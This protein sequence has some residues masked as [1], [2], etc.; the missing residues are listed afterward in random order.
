MGDEKLTEETET[1]ETVQ[2]PKVTADYIRKQEH[3]KIYSS[4][5]SF[6][7]TAVSLRLEDLEMKGIMK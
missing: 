3:F 5:D 2:I 1:Y 4:L 7:M 6:V